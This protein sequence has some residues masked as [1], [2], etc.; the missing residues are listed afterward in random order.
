SPAPSRSRVAVAKAAPVATEE[1]QPRLPPPPSNL[2]EKQPQF[3]AI[4]PPW[5]RFSFLRRAWLAR[6]QEL[7]QRLAARK[8]AL[9]PRSSDHSRGSL[10]WSPM[11]SCKPP[12]V[13]GRPAPVQSTLL[14]PVW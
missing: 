9:W 13:L 8:S 3:A 10:P 14:L 2:Q 4:F 11:Q 5:R 1:A 12:A 6:L 7:A